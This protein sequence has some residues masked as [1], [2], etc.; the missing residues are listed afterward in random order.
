M[1]SLGEVVSSLPVIDMQKLGDKSC[2]IEWAGMKRPAIDSESAARRVLDYR[3]QVAGKGGAALAGLLPSG[4]GDLAARL[5]RR[6][7]ELANTL[8]RGDLANQ[9]ATNVVVNASRVM[10]ATTFDQTISATGLQQTVQV[11]ALV[12]ERVRWVVENDAF[13]IGQIDNKVERIL[14]QELEAS[15]NNTL[16]RALGLADGE[17]LRDFNRG[18]AQE[19]GVI[20]F[21]TTNGVKLE[22]VGMTDMWGEA[23][24]L[25][26]DPDLVIMRH[27]R[28]YKGADLLVEGGKHEGRHAAMRQ[29]A[30]YL[31]QDPVAVAALISPREFTLGEVA[32][33][34]LEE[35]GD[36]N[37]V[38]Q[39]LDLGYFGAL[40]EGKDDFV[41][42]S[43]FGLLMTTPSAIL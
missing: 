33:R 28:V 37:V 9:I 23:M 30:I 43:P 40:V 24:Y 6:F 25:N 1:Q 29:L 42:Y 8:G 22:F 39:P 7:Q 35:R 17:S 2:K 41:W 38:R 34:L 12:A 14:R 32:A 4:E 20:P 10:E 5:G 19:V 21:T 27:G 15:L 3:L 16:W 31:E 11:Y 36:K 13:A 18:F 26:V